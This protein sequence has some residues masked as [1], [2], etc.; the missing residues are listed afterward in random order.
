M[1]QCE[2]ALEGRS[3]G[4]VSWRQKGERMS[5]AAQC[6]IEDGYIYRVQLYRSGKALNLGVMMPEGQHFEL[7]RS[8]PMRQCLWLQDGIEARIV[9]SLPG[10]EPAMEAYGPL[11]HYRPIEPAFTTGD[12]GIDA[13]IARQSG[14]VYM[15]DGQ[16]VNLAYPLALGKETPFAPYLSASSSVVTAEGLFGLLR[17]S[18]N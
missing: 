9:R 8:L 12:A 4:L 6:P 1:P 15:R 3:I 11:D 18:A 5:F 2:L 13:A 16:A 10:Q 7:K 14:I 17:C